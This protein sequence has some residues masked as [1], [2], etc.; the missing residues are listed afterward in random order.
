MWYKIRAYVERMLSIYYKKNGQDRDETVKND[1]SVRDWCKMLQADAGPGIND[2]AG[3]KTFP[4]IATFYE[5]V[6]AVTMCIHRRS[7]WKGYW[8]ITLTITGSC[9]TSAHIDQLPA[10]LLPGLCCQQAA[11]SLSRTTLQP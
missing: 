1:Q 10:E 11:M 6:D 2:G 9:F 8:H 3:M 5:L 7:P 4:T